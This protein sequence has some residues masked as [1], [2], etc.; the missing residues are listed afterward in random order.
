[1]GGGI[2]VAVMVFTFAASAAIVDL[3]TAGSSGTVN[4]AIFEQINPQATG[5]GVINSFVEIGGNTDVVHAYNTT[6]NNVLDN[7]S[8][9]VFNHA[10]LL[11]AVPIVNISGTDYRQFLLDI[12]Q[13]GADPLLSLDDIQVFVSNTPNQ[14]VT[15]FDGN[16]VLQLAD[17]TLVYRLDTL[18]V[19]NYIL[20]D[21]SLNT[22][23]GSGDMF[24]YIPDSVF[25]GGQYVYLYSLFGENHNNNDGFEE[26][27][28]LE[29]TVVPE[30]ASLSLLG[31][32]VAGL[33]ARGLRRR[34]KTA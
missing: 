28:V 20:L 8:S 10:L 32:G 18:A 21:Y 33:A 29:A 26:W 5:T 9:D 15:T 31:L 3:T 23:S 12:N 16:G 7:G 34:M 30:P 1:M 25:T 19:D 27:A 4:G 11:T 14:S 17:A 24:M 6:V 13:T 22:G 2:A